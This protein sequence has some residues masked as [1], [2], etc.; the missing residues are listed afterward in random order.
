MNILHALFG[1]GSTSRCTGS[2]KARRAFAAAPLGDCRSNVE[3][4]AA[5]D[6]RDAPSRKC[7]LPPIFSIRNTSTLN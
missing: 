7:L 5:E 1:G 2:A 6:P 3:D 4:N